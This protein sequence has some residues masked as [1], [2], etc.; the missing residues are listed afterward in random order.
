MT[1][2]TEPGQHT[3]TLETNRSPLLDRAREELGF[4][5]VRGPDK[6]SD[7]SVPPTF[8]DKKPLYGPALHS[9]L[10][11]LSKLEY[12][13]ADESTQ[14]P[15]VETVIE[16]ELGFNGLLGE[17]TSELDQEAAELIIALARLDD[18]LARIDVRIAAYKAKIERLEWEQNMH[19]EPYS[20]VPKGGKVHMQ[21]NNPTSSM[22]HQIEIVRDDMIR[23]RAGILE[24]MDGVLLKQEL[25]M[26]KTYREFQ[27][28]PYRVDEPTSMAG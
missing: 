18:E 21:N 1:V 11:V 16:R 7:G 19:R 13:I 20:D 28:R 4:R 24:E 17:L 26:D 3:N 6:L 22:K 5:A 25:L 2:L 15:S 23:R 12:K 8:E 14:I 10:K 9:L 27:Q